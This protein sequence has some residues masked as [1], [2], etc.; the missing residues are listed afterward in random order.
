RWRSTRAGASEALRHGLAAGPRGQRVIDPLLHR[1]RD[2]RHMSIG[3]R[4]VGAARMPAGEF[5]Q[6]AVRRTR[7]MVRL[8][9]YQ[10]RPVFDLRAVQGVVN[11]RAGDGADPSRRPEPHGP[12]ADQKRL[13]GAV[14]NIAEWDLAVA[15][16]DPFAVNARF[17]DA[18]DA[19][20]I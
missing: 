20:V 12:L 10:A 11:R 4:E 15:E 13:G 19:G 8:A 14:G 1:T 16:E 5:V 2:E 3:E 9:E 6:L 7:R 17:R 18:E